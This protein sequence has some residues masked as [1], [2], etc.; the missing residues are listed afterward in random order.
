MTSIYKTI[1]D[2]PAWT[3]VDYTVFTFLII[4][5]KE[6][7]CHVSFKVTRLSFSM[8]HVN[9]LQQTV[10]FKTLTMFVGARHALP[11][12]AERSVQKNRLRERQNYKLQI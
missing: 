8:L 6:C 7:E 4:K 1:T 5:S 10:D 3:L 11:H 2:T 12:V 9:S